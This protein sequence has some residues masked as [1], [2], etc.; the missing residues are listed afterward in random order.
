M[1]SLYVHSIIKLLHSFVL[2]G[3]GSKLLCVC[4]GGGLL[5]KKDCWDSRKKPYMSKIVII[6][7][8]MYVIKPYNGND[9]VRAMIYDSKFIFYL[10]S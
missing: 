2:R 9:Q 8:Y 1:H 5:M 3:R 4:V 10:S 6:G 7:T